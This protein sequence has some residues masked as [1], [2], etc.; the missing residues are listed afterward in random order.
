MTYIVEGEL[1]AV[2]EDAQRG[3]IDGISIDGPKQK[4]RSDG[5]GNAARSAGSR[6][7]GSL[8]RGAAAGSKSKFDSEVELVI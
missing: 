3:T 6:S 4:G 7:A 2:V 8:R 1:T 5:T